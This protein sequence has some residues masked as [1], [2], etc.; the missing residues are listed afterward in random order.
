M[1]ERLAILVP[2]RDRPDHLAEFVPVLHKYL[3]E[4]KIDFGIFIINQVDTCLFNRAKLLNVGFLETHTDYTYSAYHD[5]DM[6]PKKPGAGYHY[7]SGARQVHS[8][9]TSSM[10]GISITSNDVN[11]SINGWSNNY[12]GWGG[13]DRNYFHRLRHAD[14]KFDKSQ[15]FRSWDW[16]KEH[17]RELKGYHEKSRKKFRDAQRVKTKHYKAN[18]E[19]YK[20]D[21]LRNC[22]YKKTDFIEHDTHTILDVDLMCEEQHRL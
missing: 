2:Y 5:V 17:F 19:L 13:E 22:F 7:C 9:T 11:M 16:A 14:V 21:G 20:L 8:P 15:G 4:E 10:G 6:L 3:T 18:P 12:W 1:S